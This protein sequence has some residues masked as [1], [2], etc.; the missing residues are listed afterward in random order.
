MF[1]DDFGFVEMPMVAISFL[2]LWR[3]GHT[4]IF[5]SFGIPGPKFGSTAQAKDL[6]GQ[7]SLHLAA[8]CGELGTGLGSLGGH[9]PW[10]SGG[11]DFMFWLQRPKPSTFAP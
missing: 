8:Q 7:T 6:R 9:E 1:Q 11:Q 4:Y 10:E 2:R 3:W 5:F